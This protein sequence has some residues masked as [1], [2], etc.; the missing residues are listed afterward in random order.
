LPARAY[1]HDACRD[2]IALQVL[3]PPSLFQRGHGW[4]TQ[5]RQA[6]AHVA[7]LDRHG[8]EHSAAGIVTADAGKA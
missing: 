1:E 4:S 8:D 5:A 2:R 3:D 6:L 7:L